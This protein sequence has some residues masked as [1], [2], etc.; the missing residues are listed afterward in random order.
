M[1]VKPSRNGVTVYSRNPVHGYDYGWVVIKNG[2]IS[3]IG[4][5]LGREGGVYWRRTDP[6][7]DSLTSEA[8]ILAGKWGKNFYVEVLTH[9]YKDAKNLPSPNVADKRYRDRIVKLK[10]TQIKMRERTIRRLRK[11]IERIQ[12][13]GDTK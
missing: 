4:Q 6:H 12:K 13:G 1:K 5:D 11:D 3:E 9:A 8:Q 10:E 2:R 7:R